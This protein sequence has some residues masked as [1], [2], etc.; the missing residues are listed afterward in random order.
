MVGVHRRLG[1]KSSSVAVVIGAV[2][3]IAAMALAVCSSAIASPP[4][5]EL[6][7]K[8]GPDGSDATGFG[9]AGPV[10]VDQ[11]SHLVYAAAGNLFNPGRLY[12]FDGEG[13]P[14][15]WSGA[16]PY[17]AGNEISGLEFIEEGK[18]QI[19]VDSITHTIYVTSANSI[20]AFQVSGEPSEFTAGPGA[21]SSTI[22]GFSQLSGLA[23]DANGYIYASDNTEGIVKIFAPSGEEVTQ[24]VAENPA[25][26][27]VDAAGAVYVVSFLGSVTKFTPS[28]FPVTGATTYTAAPSPIDSVGAE[29]V[30]VDPATNDA[31]VVHSVNS[32]QRGVSVYAEDGTL[33][34]TF[35]EPGSEGEVFLADGIAIDGVGTKVYVG[36]QPESESELSQVYLFQIEPPASPKIEVR[37]V[38]NVSST[39]ATLFARINPDQRATTYQFEYGPNDCSTSV[40]TAVPVGGASIGAGNDGV[41]VSQK[42]QGLSPGIEYHYLVVAENELGRTEAAGTFVTQASALDFS[43]ADGRAW[44]MVSPPNKRGARLVGSSEGQVQA[45][46]S[47]GAIAYLSRGSIDSEPDGNRFEW[48]SVLSRRGPS[49]WSSK[50]I[51]T[52]NGQVTPVAVGQG[53]EYKLFSSDLTQAI[54]DQRTDTPLSPEASERGPYLWKDGEPPIYRP[55]VTGKEGFANVPPG[56]SFGGPALAALSEVL[57]RDATPDLSHVVLASSIPLV[58]GAPG[59]PGHPNLYEWVNGILRPVGVLPLAE[60]GSLVTANGPGS[61]EVSMRH[62][63]SD[64]GSRVFWTGAEAPYNHLYMRDFEVGETVKVDEVQPGASGEGNVEPVFQGASTNGGV[65]YFTDTQQL[66]EDASLAGPDLY[67]CEIVTTAAGCTNLVDLTA[68]SGSSEPI[69]VLGV[70]SAQSEDGSRVYFAAEGNLDAEA[71]QLGQNAVANR[72]NMFLWE[73]GKGL[74]FI[75]ALASADRPDWGS[76]TPGF[77]AGQTGHLAAAASPDGRYF[78]FMSEQDLIGRGNVDVP[79]GELVEEAFRFDAE[80]GSLDCVSCS[81]EGAAPRG[82]KIEPDQLV[83]SQ[84][85]WLDRYVAAT[86]PE[87][88]VLSIEGP[89]VYRPRAVLDNGRVFFNSFDSLVPADSNKQWDVYQYEDLGVGDCSSGSGNAGV[90]RSGEGCVSLISSGT[91]E[92]EAG[93]LDAS[94]SGNDVFFLAP[95]RLSV[96]DV[97]N[98]LDV[99]DARVN[100]APASSSPKEQCGSGESCRPVSAQ[101]QDV[102][103]SSVS[104]KGSGNLRPGRKCPKGKHRVKRGRRQRCVSSKGRKKHGKGRH[105]RRAKQLK[106]AER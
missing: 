48:A 11:Q 32:G 67:R 36:N 23:V 99:Y 64:N 29:A 41:W 44:E 10:A 98:E 71:N 94:T 3:L 61:G 14:V 43:L 39:S 31:Y 93:F 50:D 51:T 19:A 47:G 26:L 7:E 2:A 87:P 40:C 34:T 6:I 1:I 21:G 12:K 84:K 75:A 104:F 65:V 15:S 5:Y 28:S 20:R 9:Q 66:T 52:A 62:A 70:V 89:T 90:K 13:N 38:G 91:G 105:H 81:P 88:S 102:A 86:L 74:R 17:I 73:E 95:A 76:P 30:G 37:A 92:T 96:T 16:A 42:I 49:G 103:P 57:F 101:A 63:I 22:G 85:Q 33:I 83:D 56:T 58:E 45:A 46:A 8:F 69:K 100:G 4:R 72:P 59:S 18:V 54:L 55:L 77:P 27:A 25:N 35:A 24:F 78:A 53:G 80:T 97:D 60:G 106:R 68:P 82:V 79:S